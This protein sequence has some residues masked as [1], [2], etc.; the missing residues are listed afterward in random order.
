MKKILFIFILLYFTNCFSQTIEVTYTERKVMSEEKKSQ[1]P[2][3]MRE[4][5][6]KSKKFKLIYSEGKSKY[7]N[8]EKNQDTIIETVST[9]E[10]I[11]DSLDLVQVT[12]KRSS[13]TV[14][15]TDKYYY[16]DYIKN[17]MLFEFYTAQRFF[18]GKDSL[19]N[20]DW[21]ITNEFRKIDAYNCKKA[22]SN[23]Y[24]YEF[25][26]WYTEDVP[27]QTGPE[28]FDGLPGLIIYVGTPYFEW[29]ANNIIYSEKN[30]N[31]EKPIFNKQNTVSMKEFNDIISS[32]MSN[33]SNKT[34]TTQDGNKTLKKET[35]IIK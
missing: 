10:N 25:T 6:L 24:G 23:L 8:F 30:I 11:I 26:A 2:E 19:L 14:K 32:K 7:Y 1:I 35:I 3:F 18:Y 17:E 22:T 21:K 4:E 33:L 28:K 29:V 34:T 16:K 20:W 13:L 27:I 15:D 5:V 9:S 31:I 12:T